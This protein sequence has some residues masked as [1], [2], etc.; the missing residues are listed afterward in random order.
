MTH[1]DSGFYAGTADLAWARKGLS[2]FT[3]LPGCWKETQG[4]AAWEVVSH[5]IQRTVLGLLGWQKQRPWAPHCSRGHQNSVSCLPS[6]KQQNPGFLLDYSCL[7]PKN[8][9]YLKTS[10]VREKN[11][12]E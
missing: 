7:F 11:K 8:F 2:K 3:L 4:L 5:L 10:E 1:G 12:M 9:E 6:T